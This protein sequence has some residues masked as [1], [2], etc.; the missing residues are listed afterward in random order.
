MPQ[1]ALLAGIGGFLGAVARHLVSTFF[2]TNT[3]N[4]LIPLGTLTVNLSGCLFLGV[5]AAIAE[6]TNLISKELA[7]C[8]MTGFL[9]SFT[10]FS[11]FSVETM[12]LVRDQ[13]LLLAGLNVGLHVILGFAAAWTG[14]HM[15]LRIIP[16]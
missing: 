6:H 15:S 7:F 8:L 2:S 5:L 10:T 13:N 11:T 9:G 1:Q 14:F 16:A 12:A 4:T 3:E